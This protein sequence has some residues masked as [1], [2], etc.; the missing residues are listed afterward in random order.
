MITTRF[1]VPLPHAPALPLASLALL[2]TGLFLI[3]MIVLGQAI[4]WPG[5]LRLPAAEALPLIA[6]NALAVQIGYWAYLLTSL[7]FLP[8]A[9]A[10]RSFLAE[11]GA[12]GALS[13]TAAAL[14]V[15][16]AVFKMLGIVRWLS[17]MPSLAQ[18]YVGN[19]DP[20]VRAA[21]EVAYTALN[22][23]AGAVGE[24]LGVQLVSGLWLIFAGLLLGRIGAAWTGLSGI[25]IG[26]VFLA[27]CLRTIEPSFAAL[28]SV[29]VP[30]ALAWF[31]AFALAVWKRG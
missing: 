21:V 4:G 6:E 20:V 15:A 29:A 3:P 25:L 2:Q 5:S 14:G 19:V 17:A 24:L 8:L 10:F 23:Y 7:A 18:L 30:L 26:S 16:V 13:D 11:R 31:P 22:G 12:G 27:T 28:Q 1:A 9:L